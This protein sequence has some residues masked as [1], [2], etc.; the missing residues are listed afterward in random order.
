MVNYTFAPQAAVDVTTARLVQQEGLSGSLY[1]SQAE[2]LSQT[3]PL[4]V[5]VAGGVST[6][7][8]G[9]SSFGQLPEFTVAD[10][11]Q[12]WWGPGNGIAVHLMSFDGLLT[13]AEFWTAALLASA[14]TWAR[15]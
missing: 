10:H 2:A 14:S 13:A 12:V 11:F 5:T 6:T 15:L 3:S 1:A 4:T 7:V 9:V 8:L